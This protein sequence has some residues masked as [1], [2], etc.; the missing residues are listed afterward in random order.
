MSARF[1]RLDALRGAAAIGVVAYHA[2]FA[3]YFP[4]YWGSMDFFFVL[5][6]FLITRSLLILKSSQ[7]GLSEFFFYRV[8]RVLPVMMLMTLLVELFVFAANMGFL[9][10]GWVGKLENGFFC[11]YFFLLQNLDLAFL[12]ESY[13]PRGIGLDHFWSLI[14][15]EQYYL[16]WG[17]IFFGIRKIGVIKAFSLA[18]VLLLMAG[19][20]RVLDFSWWFL[21]ARWDG[22][23]VGS[24]MALLIFAEIPG[25]DKAKIF[26]KRICFMP[27]IFALAWICWNSGNYDISDV[28]NFR[29]SDVWLDVYAFVAVSAAIVFLAYRW[30][31]IC[32]QSR[33]LILNFFCTV[34]LVSYELYVVHYPLIAILT[35]DDVSRL[36]TGLSQAEP[37]LLFSV[38]FVLSMLIAAGLYKF[39]SKPLL[40]RRHIYAKS[41]GLLK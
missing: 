3:T 4:W 17:V 31:M 34:G 35:Q 30:D 22:F 41:W 5:S 40:A 19:I 33:S 18:F 24:L 7:K 11:Y 38:V 27:V 9:R 13:F 32:G 16:L 37:V 25:A 21:L 6:G 10:P 8:L 23:I 14:I 20:L 39:V 26:F 2:G 1:Q 15:E 29:S 36:Y 28:A 12:G